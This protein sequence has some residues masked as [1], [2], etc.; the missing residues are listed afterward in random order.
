MCIRDRREARESKITGVKRLPK[1]N[2]KRLKLM[3]NKA[4]AGL[5]GIAVGLIFL[6]EEAFAG[7]VAKKLEDSNSKFK[8]NFNEFDKFPQNSNKHLED[9]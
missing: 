4:R 3:V 8:I 5:A 6:G 2:F 9:R 7:K 1:N